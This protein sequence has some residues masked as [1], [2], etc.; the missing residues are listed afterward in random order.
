MLKTEKIAETSSKLYFYRRNPSSIVSTMNYNKAKDF[1]NATDEMSDVI[2]NKYK[3]LKQY[4]NTIKVIN[5]VTVMTS[6]NNKFSKTFAVG[7][8]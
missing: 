5:R 8:C 6:I 3:D 7:F 1:I 2:I 4:C